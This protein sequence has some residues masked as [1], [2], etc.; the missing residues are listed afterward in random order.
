M[1]PRLKRVTIKDVAARAGVSP[2]A[3]S[4]A[5]NGKGESL[6]EKTR[7]RIRAAA[8][9]LDYRPDYS[10]RAMVTGKT[11]IVG[12][13]LPDISNPFFAQL[14]GQIQTALAARG[15]DVMLCNS[16]EKAEN[17][18]HSIRLLAGRGVDGLILA[19]ASESL[20]ADGAANLR[21]VL[22]GARLPVLFLD[23]CY[24]GGMPRVSVDNEDSGYRMAQYLL[25]M[26]HTKIGVVTGPLVLNSSRN[27]LRGVLRALEE[28]NLS[29]PEA[30]IYEGRYDAKSG[31][32]GAEKLLKTDVTAIFAFSDVQAC[33]VYKR[34][35]E[36]G[37][38]IPEDISVAGFDDTFYSAVCVPPLTTMRQPLG[39][40]S[41]AACRL[42]S[43]MMEGGGA[44][45]EVCVPADLVVRGSVKRLHDNF[46]KQ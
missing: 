38:R 4:I 37:K 41:A 44:E 25:R 23:R 40:I 1:T 21:K 18:L 27:R 13:V 28:K 19:P 29:L 9:E 17:G 12:I 24:E 6:P 42:L 15:Y 46:E 45:E 30:Y 8:D 32:L 39:E 36:S 16:G 11:H 2:S 20:T 14:V 43:K 34:L 31:I 5:L 3:V 22:A 7:E 33:G 10:A 26:G 35:F